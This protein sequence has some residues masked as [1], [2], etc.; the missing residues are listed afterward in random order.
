[1]L[2]K[3]P[4]QTLLDHPGYKLKLSDAIAELAKEYSRAG[5]EW[6]ELKG[7]MDGHPLYLEIL[8]RVPEL[9]VD[10]IVPRQLID[11]FSCDPDVDV[12]IAGV[13]VLGCIG[14][15]AGSLLPL[16]FKVCVFFG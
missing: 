16:I 11:A 9:L 14:V 10:G 4:D 13:K 8:S 6:S 12:L 7:S 5:I 15:E 3:I 1:M 2:L